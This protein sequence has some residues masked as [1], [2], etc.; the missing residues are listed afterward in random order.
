MEAVDAMLSTSICPPFISGGNSQVSV[1]RNTCVRQM[2]HSTRFGGRGE[3]ECAQGMRMSIADAGAGA[4]C[5]HVCVCHT[6]TRAG[7]LRTAR[8]ARPCWPTLAAAKPM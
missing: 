3:R 5:A 8:V 2:S 7:S 6:Q 4:L 1:R